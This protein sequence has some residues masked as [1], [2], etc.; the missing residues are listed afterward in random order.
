MNHLLEKALTMLL[1]C[2]IALLVAIPASAAE[3]ELRTPVSTEETEETQALPVDPNADSE[4]QDSAAEPDTTDDAWEFPLYSQLDYPDKRYGSGTVATDGSGMTSLAMVAT[5]MTGHTYMP[6]ELAGYFG[7][8]G[9]NNVQRLVYGVQQLRLPYRKAKNIQ[10]IFSA[11]EKGNVAIVLMN[12]KSDFT[13]TQ[14][15]V[16]LYG[17]NQYGRVMVADPNGANYEN[18]ALQQGFAEGFEKS[19]LIKGYYGGWVFNVTSMPQ[20][21]F[22]YEEK[23]PDAES[24][25][26][27][28]ELTWEEQQ[29]LAKLI[30]LEARGEPQKGQQAVAEVVLNRLVS[31]KYGS[32]LSEV[33]YAEGAFRTVKLLPKA[34]AWQAQYDAI[35]SALE[36]PYVLPQSVIGFTTQ[37]KTDRIWGKIGAHYFYYE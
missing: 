5:Y 7:G 20:K 35:D 6:D 3:E 14:Q 18:P 11:L 8:H 4:L 24:R 29:L 23:Q 17:I 26:P 19:D 27:G 9:E 1:A 10:V 28:V 15:F 2:A 13:N 33:I 36:G 21:P 32:T 25:Y 37:P 34:E 12:Q 16:V 31:G 22:I 30:W